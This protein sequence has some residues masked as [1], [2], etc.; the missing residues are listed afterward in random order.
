[1]VIEKRGKRTIVEQ[2]KSVADTFIDCFC[3]PGDNSGDFGV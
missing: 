3:P 1:M 2:A